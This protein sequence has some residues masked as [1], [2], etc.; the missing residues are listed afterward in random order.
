MTDIYIPSR[1]VVNIIS[2]PFAE[3]ANWTS[4]DAPH[5]VSEWNLSGLT[6]VPSDYWGKE[7]PSRV[8]ESAFALE[9]ELHDSLPLKND[10]GKVTGTIVI[11]R[12]RNYV[13]NEG[14]Y[15]V[16]S[17]IL[18]VYILLTSSPPRTKVS[19]RK[20]ALSTSMPCCQLVEEVELPIF[21]RRMALSFQDQPGK[22]FKIV[23]MSRMLS[24]METQGIYDYF[25]ISIAL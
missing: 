14:G 6:P 19:D 5:S 23:M 17:S 4:V 7:G 12:I 11:G 3:A 10:D 2:E 16:P 18:L 22:T 20:T 24:K 15:I 25:M 13:M 8:G 21:D 1:F 9:C